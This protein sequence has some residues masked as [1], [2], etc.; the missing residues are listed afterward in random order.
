M[1]VL[2]RDTVALQRLQ[3]KMTTLTAVLSSERSSK[4]KRQNNHP[5]KLSL[6]R[7]LKAFQ[8]PFFTN[9]TFPKKA[10]ES[11]PKIFFLPIGPS[12]KRPF[13]TK[14]PSLK[15]HFKGLFI[16]IRSS[17]KRPFKAFQRPFFT[18]RTV[19]KK[20]FQGI[21]KVFY[22]LIGPFP[23]TSFK[24]IFPLAV[25]FWKKVLFPNVIYP[26]ILSLRWTIRATYFDMSWNENEV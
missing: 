12:L 22:L 18:N 25:L 8:R 26:N 17:L 1:T 23:E 24:S 19:L 21:S 3:S 4:I 15:R 16:P 9:R 10:F 7:P 13:Y 11:L 2:Q 6:K 20:A 5:I 14:R